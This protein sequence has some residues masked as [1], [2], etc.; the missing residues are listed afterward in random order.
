[1]SLPDVAQNL[2]ITSP[3]SIPKGYFRSKL[4]ATNNTNNQLLAAASPLLSLLERLCQSPALP[5]IEQA[6]ENIE[7]EL[8]AF[9]S[10]LLS[11]ECLE[12]F[13][14]IAHYL[15]YATI[16]EI[17]GK[18]YLRVYGEEIN[19]KSF[20]PSSQDG[21]GPEKKFFKV[22]EHLK[23]NSN[24]YLDL[25]E[26]AYYCLISG[27]EGHYHMKANGRQALDNLIEELH[28]LILENRVNKPYKL[29]QET[30]IPTFTRSNYKPYII[31]STLILGL[32]AMTYFG[33]HALLDRQAKSVIN[34]NYQLAHLD[35]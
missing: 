5:K 32:L 16:D 9:N 2:K 14:A 13:I 29:F 23:E 27:F 33:S 3:N 30:I 1:M 17:L 6:I 26:L 10:R 11:K 18:N 15:L 24:Q 4:F 31:S 8:Y 22:V 28:L 12:E 34:N 21:I 25:I 20:T 19:F 35:N 7:H